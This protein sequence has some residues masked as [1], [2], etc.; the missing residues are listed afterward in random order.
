M[1]MVDSMMPNTTTASS[2][3]VTQNI[4]AAF[5]LMVKAMTMAPKTMKG[6]RIKRRS[7]RFTPL[8]IW[9]MSEVIR[10]INVDVPSV[11]ISW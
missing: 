1:G 11:S 2:G 5:T 6:D 10:V 3:I 4:K 9:L 8:S 7:V